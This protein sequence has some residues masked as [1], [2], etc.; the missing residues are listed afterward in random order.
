MTENSETDDDDHETDH[1]HEQ[2]VQCFLQETT[3]HCCCGK[4]VRDSDASNLQSD[5]KSAHALVDAHEFEQFERAENRTEPRKRE[6]QLVQFAEFKVVDVS[7]Y[8]IVETVAGLAADQPDPARDETE[9]DGQKHHLH[10]EEHGKIHSDHRRAANANR[11]SK[12]LRGCMRY[13]ARGRDQ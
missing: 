7:G 11:T 9:I 2:I 13:L 8:G 5:P 6:R 1:E 10:V 12:M 3:K 4:S